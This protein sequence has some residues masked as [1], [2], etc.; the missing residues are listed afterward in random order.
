VLF[1]AGHVA[2]VPVLLGFNH[3]EGTL[4]NSAPTDLNASQYETELAKSI[5]DALAQQVAVEYPLADEESPWWAVC[6]VLRDSQMLCPGT[7][8]ATWLSDP[9]RGHAAFVYYYNQIL[10]LTDIIDLFRNLRVFHGSELV[11]VFDLTVL[12]WNDAEVAMG[13]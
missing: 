3:D 2:P 5:G 10:I 1:A 8:A 4:F 11:S 7:Q 6:S 9:A 12:L 13:A